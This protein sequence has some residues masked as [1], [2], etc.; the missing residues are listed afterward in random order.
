MYVH[1]GRT[2]WTCTK[3]EE[4]PLSSL[5]TPLRER[6]RDINPLMHSHTTADIADEPVRALT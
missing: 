5:K 4:L 6:S 2:L 3:A 1:F